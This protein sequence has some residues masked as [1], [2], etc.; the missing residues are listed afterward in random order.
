[1]IDQPTGEEPA[2]ELPRPRGPKPQIHQLRARYAR[3]VTPDHIGQRVSVRH[4]LDDPARGPIPSDVV[5]RLVG[6]DAEAML[7]VD[8]Q[9]QLTVLD[10]TRVLSSRVIPPHPKLPAEPEVGTRD[11]PLTR[12]AARVLLLDDG[13]RVLLVAHAPDPTRRVWTAP[14]GG[15][16][17]EETHR[18]AAHRELEEEIGIVE[19]PGPWIWSRRVTFSFRGCWIDQDERWFLARTA[20]TEVD[21]APLDDPG[22]ITARWWSL[23]E[24]RLTDVELAPATLAHH[25]GALLAEGPPPEPIDVGR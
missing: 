11:H 24:L 9:G 3:R 12:R 4:L 23:E 6:A 1:V 16:R 21:A 20:P 7:I 10:T 13:D 18:A 15:L 5:G 19:E 22:A 25:L 2:P 14:G 8:R 17:E